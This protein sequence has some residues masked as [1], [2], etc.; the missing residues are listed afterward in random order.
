MTVAF[1]VLNTVF[2]VQAQEA[3]LRRL[4]GRE[5]QVVPALGIKCTTAE[6]RAINEVVEDCLEV[7]LSAQLEIEQIDMEEEEVAESTVDACKVVEACL[8]CTDLRAACLDDKT[9]REFKDS[10]SDVYLML[11]VGLDQCHETQDYL[12]SGRPMQLVQETS[13][14][15]WQVFEADWNYRYCVSTITRA[16]I[17]GRSTEEGF[18]L[19]MP[20]LEEELK[21]SEFGDLMLQYDLEEVNFCDFS[22]F[23]LACGEQLHPCYQENLIE[24]E[25]L[26]FLTTLYWLG[27]YE[28]PLPIWRHLIEQVGVEHVLELAEHQQGDIC[29]FSSKKHVEL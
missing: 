26:K 19:E 5:K 24:V 4:G 16:A 11:G 10:M 21:E 20:A 15:P 22:Q 28:Q 29:S 3:S 9:L 6:I 2:V 8:Y 7:A 13:C 23:L 25:V 17:T 12:Q 27:E 14:H 18:V 1:W